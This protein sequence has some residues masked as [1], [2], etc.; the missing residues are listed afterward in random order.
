M[1]TVEREDLGQPLALRA[2][3]LA[4]A[5]LRTASERPDDVAL[6]TPRGRVQI[7]WRE[8]RERVERIA[9]GLAGLGVG[10]GDTVALMLLNRPE[11][12][13]VDTAALMLGAT[14]FSIYNTLTA[15]QVEYLFTNAGNRV[16]V[17]E[18]AFLP[19]VGE[20]RR[21]V[22][23]IE[24]V[25]VV[26]HDEYGALKLDELEQKGASSFDFMR[27]AAAVAPE[28]IATIVY[29]SGTTGPPKGVEL[30]HA[31]LIA[32]CRAVATRL[33]TKVGGRSASFLPAAHVVER[34]G[35][36]YFLSMMYGATITAIEDPRTVAARLRDV[37]PT[38]W[39][40]VPRTWEKIKAGLEFKGILDPAALPEETRAAVRKRIGLDQAQWL[41]CGAAPCPI[42]VLEYFDAL[43]LP[44]LEGWGM[45]E[46]SCCATINPPGAARFGT[47]GPA[48]DGIE[49]KLA[50]DGEVLVRGPVVMAGYRGEPAM[51]ATAI[52]ADGWLHTGDI[53]T[54]DMDRYLTIVDRKKE[55]IINS[56]G[57][58]MSPANIE[59]RL[60]A[61]HPLIG[62]AVAVGDRRPYVVA[63]VVLD[64]EVAVH[65]AAEHGIADASTRALAR[66]PSVRDV[67]SEAVRIA[68]RKLSRV[69]Q[70][71]TFAI[72]GDDWQP[73]G[74]E[75]TP[76]MKL[77]RKPI[78]Q[79]Y[80]AQIDALYAER[81]PE[82]TLAAL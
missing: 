33:P 4:E 48:L 49:L 46:T 66:H 11:F 69:E 62:Q 47:C 8:Y 42:E 16:V 77:K 63:L 81:R 55:I 50:P 60:T 2:S 56:A 71:K 59:A 1:A 57:K 22:G 10:R 78:A 45:S 61:A 14:P 23:A 21:R 12:H 38:G 18:Q 43:G 24:H 6:R 9:A 44:I 68:N 82:D 79:K 3:T 36:H 41:L 30:T 53:G 13:L 25:I 20:A 70:I 40:A 37:R 19:V 76:T 15:E 34:C 64:S 54:R 7:T 52:D 39:G 28:D 73:G 65:F 17:T 32:E 58:N 5:F 74:D 26:D 75:L 35:S 72:I 67:I 27:H 29:T 31:N 80:A 51:T